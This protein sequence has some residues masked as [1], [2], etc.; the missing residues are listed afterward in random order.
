MVCNQKF[1][2]NLHHSML[3]KSYLTP[4]LNIVCSVFDAY[5]A[6][7][8]LPKDDEHLFE[9]SDCFS[10]GENINKDCVLEP[11][12]GLVGWII[13]N[14]K[15]LLVNDF[16]RQGDG[17]G[18]YH[19]DAEAKIKSF[20]GCPLN[21][22][23]G[24]LCL[25]SKRSFSFST[26]DQ[27]ILHQFTQFIEILRS[28]LY[29]YELNQEKYQYY[30]CLQTIQALKN[31]STRWSQYLDGFLQILS[32]FT[33]FRHCFFAS[34]DKDGQGFYLEGWNKPI[35]SKQDQHTQRFDTREGL[36]GWVFRN[37]SRI[38]SNEGKHGRSLKTPL[39]RKHRD[40]PTFQS[41]ICLPLVLNMKTRGVLVLADQDRLP[42][43]EE[44]NNFLTLITDQ[45]SLLLDNL[46]L[47]N[48]LR[49]HTQARQ[50]TTTTQGENGCS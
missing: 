32:E 3:D 19:R 47:K 43:T 13:R 11:G 17:L 22:G 41:V 21:K 35:F 1:C 18:Y 27:K 39:F 4:I 46:Y 49:Q 6:V 42:I 15:P 23:Q 26:K 9:L 29:Q 48:K 40:T 50:E 38:S 2:K 24:V 7:V 30:V 12:Q 10:L 33:Q 45:L 36:I 34:R 8:F 25:D 5:S 20:M 16:D 14:N 31:K 28:N 37:H 44:L